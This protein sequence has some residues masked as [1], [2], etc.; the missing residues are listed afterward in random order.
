MTLVIAPAEAENTV[1]TLWR[2]VP[3]ATDLAGAARIT[4]E[5]G[6]RAPITFPDGSQSSTDHNAVDVDLPLR[7]QLYAPDDGWVHSF[8]WQENGGW[9]LR[10]AHG[11]EWDGHGVPPVPTHITLYAHLAERPDLAIGRKV[12]RGEPIALS[13]NSGRFTTGPHLHFGVWRYEPEHDRWVPVDPTT[14]ARRVVPTPWPPLVPLPTDALAEGQ[15][16]EQVAQ[17]LMGN[18]ARV[19]PWGNP[20][21][22]RLRAQGWPAHVVLYEP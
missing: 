1:G 12:V 16:A 18:R 22:G 21:V 17:A 3:I 4:S 11:P 20:D 7:T 19:E 6:P 2:G 9:V 10:L 13:G 14:H 8:E 15:W 5:F